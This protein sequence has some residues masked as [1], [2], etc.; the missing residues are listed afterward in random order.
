MRERSLHN[1]VGK[2][3]KRCGSFNKNRARKCRKCVSNSFIH[4]KEKH[5]RSEILLALDM[6]VQHG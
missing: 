3:N 5:V 4:N 1:A 2:C 6:E